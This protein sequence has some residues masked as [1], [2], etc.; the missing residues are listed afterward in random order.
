MIPVEPVW[1]SLAVLG[2]SFALVVVVAVLID[3][4][5]DPK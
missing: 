3:M 4:R 1:L 5:G 2:G